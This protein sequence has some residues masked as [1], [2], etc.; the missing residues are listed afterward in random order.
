MFVPMFVRRGAAVCGRFSLIANPDELAA[1]FEVDFE[2]E[3]ELQWEPRFNIAPSQPVTTVY[4]PGPSAPRAVVRRRWGV[5][6]RPD[7]DLGVVG[8]RLDLRIQRFEIDA[9]KPE[10]SQRPRGYS[11]SSGRQS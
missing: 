8:P 7:H 11:Y 1:H 2:P 10:S 5:S 3:L 9:G 6:M 4:V